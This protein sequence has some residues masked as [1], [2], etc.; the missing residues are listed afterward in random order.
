MVAVNV[1]I[2]LTLKLD[3]DFDEMLDETLRDLI[4]KRIENDY[5]GDILEN[6]EVSQ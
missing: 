4:Y 1:K 3:F 6:M 5:I 2:E